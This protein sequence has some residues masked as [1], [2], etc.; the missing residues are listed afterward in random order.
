MSSPIVYTNDVYLGKTDKWIVGV[1]GGSY[2][3]YDIN[4]RQFYDNGL[5]G[6]SY[7]LVKY[8]T[9]LYRGKTLVVDSVNGNDSYGVEYPYSY[10]FKTV[11]KA[12]DT[13]VSGDTVFIY[14]GTYDEILTIKSGIAVRGI[15][16][17][18]VAIQKTN[19]VSD[20]TLV[21]M[22]SNCRLEDVTMNLTGAT[23]GIRLTGIEL[24]NTAPQT[25]K[26]RTAVVNVSNYNT[27]P[28]IVYG[29]LSSGTTAN[30]E[31][32][33]STNAIRASTVNV[34]LG[35]T[36]STGCA[37]MISGANRTTCRDS[38]FFAN[39]PTGYDGNTG[40]HIIACCTSSSPGNTGSLGLYSS[41]VS[42]A[43]YDVARENGN[44]ILFGFTD[45]V[46]STTNG[47][48]FNV[49]TQAAIQTFG[50]SG[51][52]NSSATYYLAPGMMTVGDAPTSDYLIS[53]DQNVIIISVLINWQGAVIPVGQTI[54]VDI[55]KNSSSSSPLY[56]G[57]LNPTTSSIIDRTKSVTFKV[58]DKM[59]IKASVSGS[60]GKGILMV[61]AT[62]Y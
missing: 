41:T 34:N 16:V 38:N 29:V 56:T 57:I 11:G 18:T 40:T 48:S 59:I 35:S 47:N 4:C 23:G 54:T 20:T 42:G 36:G 6:P 12:I 7:S 31:L 50:I 15:N 37:L 17:Q 27:Q 30:V 13:S 10:P 22:D 53:F 62:E 55:Y 58:E 60:I 39:G 9:S 2:E 46:H 8:P 1:T 19:V 28:S 49:A 43:T 44:I 32:N 14:P 21:T 24:V 26:L 33:T 61:T 3:S 51:N 25:S 45:L 5:T 52:L